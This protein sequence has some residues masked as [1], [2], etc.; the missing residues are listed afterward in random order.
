M[1]FPQ[2]TRR[3][4]RAAV[5]SPFLFVT[6]AQPSPAPPLATYR[7]GEVT[8]DEY[9][10]WLKAQNSRDDP[11]R[12]GVQLESI[13]LAE[14][15]ERAA[16]AAGLGAEA[17]VR[18]R[19]EEAER[20][21]LVQALQRRESLAAIPGDAEVE[22]ELDS[23]KAE[24]AKPRRV[25]LRNI[26]K[27]VPATAS[28][29]ER[30]AAR[31]GMEALRQRLQD[32]ADFGELA[33][34][35]SDS[36]TRFQGGAMGAVPPGVLQPPVE[37]VAFALKEG[38]LS[39]IVETPDGFTLLRCDGIIEARVM[40]RD[41]ARDR[42]RQG[43][44]TRRSEARQRAL[45]EELLKEASVQDTL[46]AALA[47]GDDHAVAARFTGGTV[48]LLELRW[49][50]GM[51]LASVT[52]D[53]LRGSLEEHVVRVKLAERARQQG[54]DAD[55]EV[56]ARVRWAR[57]KVLATFEITRRVGQF[58]V[59]PTEAEVR[60]HFAANRKRYQHPRELDF[61]VIEVPGSAA[62]RQSQDEAAAL[63]TELRA[64]GRDFAEAAR[65][66]SRHPS[67]QAGGRMGWRTARQAAV[68]GPNVF[69][70]LEL[71]QP[72]Q[73]VGPVQQEDT[74]WI[75]KLWDTRPARPLTF[76]E[77]R[78]QVENELGNARVAEL[79]QQLEAEARKALDLRVNDPV[80]VP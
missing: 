76:A 34:R 15:L 23:E 19:L 32:G 53:A 39:R 78:D 27:K 47:A 4:V 68:F 48:T 69:R 9:A 38:E 72:G 67:A 30:D 71:I 3:S 37:S 13:A 35:E 61:S 24:L 29:A 46:A 2:S 58:P 50:T 63:A 66:L 77:A 26:F 8:A 64:G 20:G 21:V 40:P 74:L 5:L 14:T 6:A 80:A 49:L 52:A 28:P 25:R 17:E 56:R 62:S 33:L 42:I 70:A 18:F 44:F 51:R 41:E 10:D 11:A 59:A 43:L 7:G 65:S 22:A 73:V 75:L 1:G 31:R 45:R 36:Q 57:A 54:L 60:S 16:L 55:P 79:Q 12:R